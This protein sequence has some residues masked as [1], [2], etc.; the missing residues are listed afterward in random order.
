MWGGACVWVRVC[1]CVSV[2]VCAFVYAQPLT[3]TCAQDPSQYPVFPWTLSDY[4]SSELDLTSAHVYRDLTRPMGELHD[5][6]LS[7]FLQRTVGMGG[8]DD[9][10]MPPFL[11]GSHYS[12]ALG[13]PMYFLVRVPPFSWLHRTYQVGVGGGGVSR[14]HT[15]AHTHTHAH[16]HARTRTHAR[17][18]TPPGRLLRRG[19]PPVPLRGRD[20]AYVQRRPV[21]G[22]GAGS[23][24]LFLPGNVQEREGVAAGQDAGGRGGGGCTRQPIP[25]R[26]RGAAHASVLPEY[27]L[28][29]RQGDVV[30]PPWAS[31]PED[32]VAKHREALESE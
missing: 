14:T 10:G 32:F 29:I 15:R 8:G 5:G 23:G 16:T 6:R 31:S 25:L 21:R 18:R 30:L 3:P 20:V 12:T 28:P 13:G 24:V 2:C 22:E 9:G 1:V 4:S 26:A 19:R 17:A 11:Y 27:P 7:H